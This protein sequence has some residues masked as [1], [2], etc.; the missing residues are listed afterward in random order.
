MTIWMLLP[1]LILNGP[2]TL[3]SVFEH[4]EG[5]A[6]VLSKRACGEIAYNHKAPHRALAYLKSPSKLRS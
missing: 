1:I 6:S 2:F 4:R 3:E 5:D